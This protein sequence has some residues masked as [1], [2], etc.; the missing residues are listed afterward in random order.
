MRAR[1]AELLPLVIA[2]APLL[3][4]AADQ[5]QEVDPAQYAEVGRRAFESGDWVHLKDNFGPFLNK[6]PLAFWLMCGSFKLFGVTSFAVRFPTLLLGALLL[7]VTARTGAL[8]FDRR[9]GLWG[10]AMLGASPALQ[11]MV[12]DPKVDMPVTFFIAAAIWLMLEARTRPAM[13]YLAWVAAALAML[14]KGPLGLVVPVLAV[15]PEGLRRPGTLWQRL[16]PFKP[17]SGPLLFLLVAAPWFY[18]NAREFGA[19][20][21]TLMLWNQGLGRLLNPDFLQNDTTPLFFLHTALWAYLPFSPMFALELLRRARDLLR[22][23]RFPPDEARVLLWWFLVPFVAV[24]LARYRLPQYCY[25]MAPPAALIAARALLSASL[26]ARPL[27]IAQAVLSSLVVALVAFLLFLCFPGSHFLVTESWLVLAAV[28]AASGRWLA[29][30]V[31]AEVRP[32]AVGLFALTAFNVVFHGHVHRAIL[33][34]QPD[35]AL[36]T[37]ARELDPEGRSIPRLGT[38]ESQA[39][40]FYARRDAVMMT[41]EELRAAAL[42]GKA[43]YAVVAEERIGELT[44]SGELTATPKLVRPQFWTSRPTLP[45]LL[46]RSRAGVVARVALVEIR[47]TPR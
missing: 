11:L 19:A 12:A 8:L 28:T 43:P 36:G 13:A 25:W 9:T 42:A 35:E 27:L 7:L 20:G 41:A 45:F 5:I 44:A 26:P 37:L 15:A 39:L 16:R 23:R 29:L 22:H 10:A 47:P 31:P 38:V 6:P 3:M 17:I 34:Y 32:M 2:F 21:P 24:S 40:A 1:A 30:R 18:E 33:E 4:G 46:R 14:A